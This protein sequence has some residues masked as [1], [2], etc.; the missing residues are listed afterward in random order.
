MKNRKAQKKI[1]N[2]MRRARVRIQA[3]AICL[4]A[5]ALGTPVVAPAQAVPESP[6][7]VHAGRGSLILSSGSSILSSGSLAGWDAPR[8][9]TARGQIVREIRDPDTGVH[10]LLVRDARHP[11]GP[12]RL[13]VSA[14]SPPPEGWNGAGTARIK[15]GL[16]LQPS[17]SGLA[18]YR[19]LIHAGDRLTVDESTPVV[20]AHLEAV[21]LSP[22]ALGS[23]FN[24]RL[25]IGGRVVRAV[26]VAPGR[27]NLQPGTAVRP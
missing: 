5:L 15:D 3:M 2:R 20:E 23:A 26:A 6:A 1:E 4:F 13:V 11:G 25:K 10:W 16:P 17:E 8:G 7:A 18:T 19:P 24:A 9:E 27:A 12:G 14:D 21:A 22:A